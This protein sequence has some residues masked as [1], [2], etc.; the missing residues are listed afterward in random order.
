MLSLLSPISSKDFN[1]NC[2]QKKCAHNFL[3]LCAE[4][5]EKFNEKLLI[6]TLRHCVDHFE[7]PEDAL[8][9]LRK[10]PPSVLRGPVIEEF[11]RLSWLMAKAIEENEDS[12]DYDEENG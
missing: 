7:Y 3:K 1:C 6:E 12:D 2:E 9:F 8:Q 5:Q 10:I 4:P 11:N